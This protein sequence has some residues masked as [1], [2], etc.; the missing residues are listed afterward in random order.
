MGDEETWAV[1]VV[2]DMAQPVR[3]PSR[4]RGLV[5]KWT[6]ADGGEEE[7]GEGWRGEGATEKKER[8]RSL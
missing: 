5:V 7:A 3:N 6:C 4:S 2:G 1:V 8:T